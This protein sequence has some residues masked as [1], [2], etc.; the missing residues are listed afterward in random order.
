MSKLKLILL[1]SLAASLGT[2]GVAHS[3]NFPGKR[4]QER[5]QVRQMPAVAQ[6]FVRQ[7]HARY[8]CEAG[9]QKHLIIAGAED[10]FSS[11]GSEPA[12]KSDRVLAQTHTPGWNAGLATAFDNTSTNRKVFSHLDLPPN[13]KR[14]L[15]MI[16]LDPIGELLQTDGMTIGNLGDDG[17]SNQQRVGY[18]Y[19]GSNWNPA[20]GSNLNNVGNNYYSDFSNMSLL[21]SGQTLESYFQSTGDDLLD[22]YVQDD[23]SVDYVAVSVCTGPEKKGMTWG[24]R[25][26]Q[27]EP[28]NGVAHVGC[29]DA[30]G[31]NCEPYNGDTTCSTQ[32]PILCINPMSLQKPQN[33]TEGQWD[34]WSGGII[35]TTDPM[36]A[37]STLAL[38]NS[39]CTAE[40][41]PGWRVAQHHDAASGR[42][43]W[44]FSAYGNVGT[45]GKRFWTD[46]DD[47]PN[48]VCWSR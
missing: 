23:H 42:S 5:P 33:L 7:Q 37:P 13:V 45:K 30:N 47:Q 44:A 4:V 19:D 16:G 10:N 43:G 35:G 3:Q 32:L 40:F 9:E 26:P 48:G 12:I 27:P 25:D 14:G 34:K 36:A 2:V 29:N 41:G 24:L 18:S 38:A 22:V 31:T 20:S 39:A 8:K 15:F 17:I 21:A 6:S 11:S 1:T 28:V 46:I